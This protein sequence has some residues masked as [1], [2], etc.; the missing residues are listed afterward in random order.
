MIENIEIALLILVGACTVAFLLGK[1]Y[2]KHK[3][4]TEYKDAFVYQIKQ[5]GKDRWRINIYDET[6]KS[7]LIS[8]GRGHKHLEDAKAVVKKL[9]TA[10]LVYTE[11][12]F[13]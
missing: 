9:Q 10:E 12:S 13:Y 1:E 4:E 3:A 11:D 7:V 2:A 5:G 6:G 8:S